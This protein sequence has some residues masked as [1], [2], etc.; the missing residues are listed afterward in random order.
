MNVH[1][2]TTA[3]VERIVACVHRDSAAICASSKKLSAIKLTAIWESV[4]I[5]KIHVTA[6]LDG[7]DSSVTNSFARVRTVGPVLVQQQI[8]V[9]ALMVLR[10]IFVK[11]KL[12]MSVSR[13]TA[14]WEYAP[15]T[16]IHVNVRLGGTVSIVTNIS[17]HARMMVTVEQRN[18]FVLRDSKATIVKELLV[19]LVNQNYAI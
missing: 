13:K 8:D 4:Q 18:V 6:F 9:N 12:A 2:K 3:L 16:K 10:V 1:V 14:K 7:T 17:V 11:L 5:K 15:I 19:Q